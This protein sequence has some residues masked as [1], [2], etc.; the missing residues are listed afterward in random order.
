MAM[1]FQQQQTSVRTA[2]GLDVLAG[3]WLIFAPFI[4]GYSAVTAAVWNDI[5]VGIVVAVLAISRTTREGIKVAWP[6][7]VNVV[8]GIWLIFA[9]F[10][11]GYSFVSAALWNDIILG[12]IVAALAT[13]GGV[14]TPG[15]EE[16]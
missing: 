1:T 2:N 7:W 15:R 10:I 13:W 12:I 14:S 11:L 6:S 3:I 4:L 8:I 5:I 16:M 9:P